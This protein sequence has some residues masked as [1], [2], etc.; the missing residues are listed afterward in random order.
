MMHKGKGQQDG[1]YH[2]KG[3]YVERGQAVHHLDIIEARMAK[4]EAM[5][6]ILMRR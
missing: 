3:Q 6:E 4:I 2:G 5:L 1:C